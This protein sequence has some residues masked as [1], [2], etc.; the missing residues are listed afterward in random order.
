MICLELGRAPKMTLLQKAPLILRVFLISAAILV[1][2]ITMAA[3]EKQNEPFEA[4]ANPRLQDSGV[5][6]PNWDLLAE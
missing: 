6:D 3:L 2:M 1:V 5:Q 4:L